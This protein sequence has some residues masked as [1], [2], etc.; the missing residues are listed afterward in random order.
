MALLNTSQLA[1]DIWNYMPYGETTRLLG[2]IPTQLL[3]VVGSSCRQD[4]AT[5]TLM[6]H[7]VLDV[8][9]ARFKTQDPIG[10]DSGESNLF[11]YAANNPVAATDPSGTTPVYASSVP[12]FG[13]PKWPLIGHCMFYK[14]KCCKSTEVLI[15]TACTGAIGKNLKDWQSW[16][17]AAKECS[18]FIVD[19]GAF[20]LCM[21]KKIAIGAGTACV[22]GSLKQVGALFL[23]CF[24]SHGGTLPHPHVPKLPKL[25]NPFTG[26][27]AYAIPGANDSDGTG[28]AGPTCGGAGS[29][30]ATGGGGSN[31]SRNSGGYKCGKPC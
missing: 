16:E 12:G 20:L 24:T 22:E 23:K 28:L 8:V 10:F 7:R 30:P 6:G 9:K 25:H 14:V 19:P 3:Y 26:A 11:R 5:N 4:N 29:P 2:S 31:R 27:S 15:G 17:K 21:A 13:K 1:S 18:P